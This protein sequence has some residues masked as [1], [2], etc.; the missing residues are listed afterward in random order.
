MPI[1]L[2]LLLLPLIE[3]AGFVMIGPYLGVAG[4][5]GVVLLSMLAGSA[6]L[7][8]E[9]LGTLIR[10][11]QS[12]AAKQTP[13]PTALD[14]ACRMLAALLLI[15]P[16]LISTALGLL[17]LLPPIRLLLRNAVLRRMRQS[18]TVAWSPRDGAVPP[19]GGTIIDA[20]FREVPRRNPELPPGA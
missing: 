6:L 7:R 4:T 2:A 8:S 9:G 3:I 14:G 20:E 5:L 1:G 15:V 12:I 11:R 16:G 19:Q 13:V 18:G 17:L 10:V